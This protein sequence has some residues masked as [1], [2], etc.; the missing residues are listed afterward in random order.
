MLS[1]AFRIL[2]ETNYEKIKTESFE[3][4]HDLFAS[5]LSKG[6]AK[7][8]KQGLHQEY[9]EIHENLPLLRGKLNLRHTIRNK[10]KQKRLLSCD[11]DHLS[12]NNT[13][14][15]ILKL[16]MHILSKNNHVS[17]DHKLALRKNMFYFTDID[18][19]DVRDI[20]WSTLTFA[21]NNRN[22]NMLINICFFVIEGLLISTEKGEFA[23]SSYLDEQTMS[24]LYER[25]VLEYF[26]FHH[27]NLKA[28]AAQVKWNIDDNAI[29]FLPVMQTD[30][31]LEKDG[32]TMII[33]TKYYE[34]SMIS[35]H[36]FDSTKYRSNNLYQIYAYV[37]N[38]DRKHTGDVSG[39]LLYAKTK[40][41]ITPNSTYSM[42]GNT[43][44]V[45]TLDLDTP[46]SL[47][48]EQLDRIAMMV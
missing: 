47:L 32:R 29:K 17:D 25:F 11:Y 28:R 34:Q 36:N 5:I 44:S 3:K 43:I 46:F 31:L 13:Y 26:R 27:P 30:I 23:L 6:I 22:Y 41:S 12:E 9:I 39:M 16:T 35:K 37:K 24:S 38:H 45:K 40:E 10:I 19:I 18:D 1:Y 15:Q 8:L 21:R 7:Q 14:N 20:N 4:I 48:S 2:K 33:D 42:D